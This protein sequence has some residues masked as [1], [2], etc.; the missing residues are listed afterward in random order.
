LPAMQV[1]CRLA[2]EHKINTLKRMFRRLA[3]FGPKIGLVMIIIMYAS[4]F[5]EAVLF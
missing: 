3:L 1:M 4:A 5:V 2:L